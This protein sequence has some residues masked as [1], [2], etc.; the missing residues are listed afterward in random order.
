MCWLGDKLEHRI[1]V[2]ETVPEYI[3]DADLE[4]LREAM[5]SKKTH[6]GVIE[7]NLLIIAL[8]TKTGLRRAEL[9]N[10]LV[11][12]INLERQSRPKARSRP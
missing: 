9:A 11:A 12:D 3:E 5:R 7:R 1:R 8:A 4:K 10:L 6:K 2:P